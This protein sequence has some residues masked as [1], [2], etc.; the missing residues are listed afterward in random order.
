MPAADRV[1]QLVIIFYI[2]LISLSGAEI[3]VNQLG[4]RNSDPKGM[5]V[6]QQA[7]SFGIYNAVNQSLVFENHLE[8]FSINDPGTG[9]DLYRGDF[10]ELTTPGYYYCKTSNGD[11]SFQFIISDTVYNSLYQKSIKG[12]YFQRC[13]FDLIGPTVGNYSHSRC[14]IYDGNFHSSTG[15]TGFSLARG[16]WH[17]AGD[18]GKYVVNAGITVGTLLMAY[19]YFTASFSQDDLNIAESGNGTLNNPYILKGWSITTYGISGIFIQNT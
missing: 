5:F 17:D 11:S 3:F 6:D 1:K 14:H 2:G 12:F 4:F 9:M 8:L 13:G 18:Y 7:D 19:E 10:S 15:S 16:G